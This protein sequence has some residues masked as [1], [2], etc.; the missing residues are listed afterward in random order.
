[1][2]L[3]K[4]LPILVFLMT[5]LSVFEAFSQN[6]SNKGT[7]FWV[8][9]A[10][11]ADGKNSRLSLFLTSTTNAIVNITAGGKALAPI[12]L[13][14]GQ[15]FPVV[16]DPNI[17]PN[18][19]ISGSDAVQVDAGIHITSDV[20]IIVYAHM[21]N[22]ARS[23]ASM[24][25][26]L[27]AL[28][29]EYY[30]I[31][32]VQTS[33]SPN[34]IGKPYS[35][36]TIV[37]VEDNTTIEI[38][39][40][41][42][43][44]NNTRSS[45]KV[46]Q[47][48]LNKGDVY[49]YQSTTDV[50]GSYIKT[51]GDC[52]PVAVF[53]GSTFNAY[54]APPDTKTGSG[55]PLYQQLFPVSAWGKN[56]ITAPFFNAQNGASDI[57]RIQVSKDNTT[58]KVSGPTGLTLNNP[59]KTGDVITFPTSVATRIE[60][61]L[62]IS[63]AQ[64]Q[65]T[66]ACNSNNSTG[67]QFPGD[68]EM[69]ILN[70]I[71]QT[72]KDITVYSAISYPA[73]PTSITKHY[74][75][76]ILK[77][78]DIPNLKVDGSFPS[79]TFKSI[80]SE[81]SFITVDVTQ[82]STSGNPAHR[83]TSSEGFIAIAYGYGT[84]ESYAYLAG[85]DLKNLN[86]NITISEPGST[87]SKSELCLGETYNVTLQLPYKTDKII[88]NLK[89]GLKTDTI[90]APIDSTSI[91]NGVTSYFYKYNI[92]AS[93]IANAGTYDL[94]ATVLNPAPTSCNAEEEVST[95]FEVFNL[96]A[97]AF[98]TDKQSACKGTIIF[99]DQS[100]AN[101]T[102]ITKWYW[103]FGDSTTEVRT[104]AAPFEHIYSRE[105]DYP[106]TLSVENEKGCISQ[107]TLAYIIHIY[108]SPEAQFV[109]SSPTCEK[110]PITFTDR[111]V[112]NEGAII[113][114]MWDF[115]DGKSLIAS[116]NSAVLHTYDT[117]GTYPVT[118]KV[119]TD[120]G[121]ESL[122]FS[123]SVQVRS[124]PK[125]D[126]EVPD[127]CLSDAF[128]QFKDLTTIDDGTQGDFTY[129]W[130]FG[131]PGSGSLNI[132]TQKDP[133][134]KY[135][136]SDVYTA[137]LTVTSKYGCSV[138][139]S[140]IFTVN[141]TTPRADFIVKNSD[142]LCSNQP[143]EFKDTSKVDFGAITRI[144]WYYDFANNPGAV[145]VDESP[146]SRNGGEKTYSH[147]Y[148]AFTTPA[149]KNYRVRMVAYS[150]STCVDDEIK[151]I[152]VLAVPDVN[153]DIPD[154]CLE[155]GTA[156]F[157]D[158][159][160]IAGTIDSF[161]YLWDFGDVNAT[162]QNP[163]VS[164][165]I[166]PSHTYSAAGT[167]HVSLT[168][169]AS[170]G[171]SET[172]VKPF[173]VSGSVPKP[174]FAVLN[175]N[176]LCTSQSVIFEDKTAVDFGEITKIEW[177]FNETEHP[178]DPAYQVTDTSPA[179]RSDASKQYIFT[180]PVFHSPMSKTITVRMKSFSGTC[181]KEITKDIVL[182]A[183]PE[184]TFNPIPAI[185]EEEPAIQLVQASEIHNFPGSGVYSGT[186]VT[187][188][189]MFDPKQAGPGTHIITYTF[190]GSNGCTDQRQQPLM[191]YA[192]PVADAG[193]DVQMLDGGQITLKPV[194]AT[195]SNLIYKWTPS[196]GLNRD[197][198]L[199][200]LASPTDDITYTLTITTDQGCS[201]S[202]DVFV[203]VLKGPEVPNAFTPNNDGVNDLWTIKYLDSYPGCTVHVYNRYGTSVFGVV[204]YPTAWDGK[205][206][207]EDLPSGTYYYVIDPKNGRKIIT[208]SLTILR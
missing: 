70:P 72:L 2:L 118:L 90:N 87:I 127:V 104:S 129:L 184:V 169:T 34:G 8:A 198:V 111:S 195:G 173:V 99:T 122:L 35:E 120:T 137:T 7:E 16:I 73:A 183:V 44:L 132:S 108:S 205:Y 18:A 202:D 25:L 185:C 17:Y 147:S 46:F 176:N 177:Y 31:S 88:W 27:K 171:C 168:V 123:S 139:I 52:K 162:A 97:P 121:C 75:N 3:K 42:N 45:G 192:T 82:S 117:A 40:I 131:D 203:K 201:A 74:L 181:E 109:V 114:W 170:N 56:F 124:L 78:S 19:Y 157:T 136:R 199:N 28:G 167:Y 159:S 68:P 49:Q 81:Y 115:G 57:I 4:L 156:T 207:G 191:V 79:G 175:E 20:P 150:G 69:T 133:R 101:D 100:S 61:D 14:A 197:D 91:V 158:K 22:A 190:V 83:I 148:P 29:N 60:A 160:S 39:P 95:N 43:S 206:K 13:I 59:Y 134:H 33:T 9:Y 5:F 161:T 37:G 106:V 189:G 163:N 164:T 113:S 92:S 140:K 63:V 47:V 64:F 130:N 67:V 36:F 135:V 80:D 143:V 180:Y 23:A 200:P 128:A 105:G 145:I 24:V 146:G 93:D 165:S 98:I 41:S 1:M 6:T 96:P 196:T 32:Y 182:K 125:V 86:A 54:C 107:P 153:F 10:S 38:V 89:N 179:L 110:Q 155:N 26:P 65:V 15:A 151:T 152:T 48:I 119:I 186:G 193:P 66:Q 149:T 174:D 51:I 12:N 142:K 141:G 30:A 126:F 76:I 77:N 53:S 85:A 55:D 62:P 188:A 103:N 102:P 166:A 116:D 50:T 208:G 84:V 21:S 144:E 138:T 58:I 11:N 94:K 172:L 204:G 112:A 178:N 71:E 154:G 194:T 187:A